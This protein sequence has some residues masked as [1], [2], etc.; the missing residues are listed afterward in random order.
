[1][2]IRYIKRTLANGLDVIVHEHRQLPM[3]AVNV[4]YH[5]GSKNERS[6]PYRICASLRAS[7]VRGITALRSG[8]FSA[9]PAGRRAVEWLDQPR[10]HQLLGSRADGR[11][12]S[13]SVDGI[14]SDGLPAAGPDQARS[15]RTSATLSSTSGGRTTR[16]APTVWPA[17]RI[18]AALFAPDHPYHWL[19]IGS[20]DDLRAASLD[21]VRDFFSTFYHPAN[22]SLTLAGDIDPET[23]FALAEEV[24]W[25][26][27]A[28]KSPGPIHG[29]SR[30]RG[31]CPA[32]ARGPRGVAAPVP[33]LAFAGHVCERRC[34]PRSRRGFDWS[35]QDVTAVSVAGVRQQIAAD[36]VAYQHSREISGVFQIAATAAPGV[37]LDD[38]YD[39]IIETLAT[40]R[41]QGPTAS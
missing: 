32:G 31:R 34:R 33:G 12:G 39:V 4:W 35:R 26:S 18:A 14:G 29:S 28:G 1:M 7:D 16:I 24:L 41:Q 36:V 13:G 17:S 15:S 2:E 27:P 21:E 6:R 30:T 8:V 38:L 37:A 23:G 11:V 22:A 9:A 10:S 5:V 19:T 3:V 40:W 25:R 20:A